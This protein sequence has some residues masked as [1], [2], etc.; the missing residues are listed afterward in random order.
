[1]ADSLI[2][3]D[4]QHKPRLLERKISLEVREASAV[5]K[6]R[7]CLPFKIDVFLIVDSLVPQDLSL[8]GPNIRG[9]GKVDS[10]MPMRIARALEV[11]YK[12]YQSLF[13]CST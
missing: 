3:V 7:K 9:K 10:T 6:D 4:K 1:M 12:R 8:S 2:K 13:T 5:I 11:K